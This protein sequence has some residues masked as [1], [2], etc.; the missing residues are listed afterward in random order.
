MEPVELPG[1]DGL[2]IVKF[3]VQTNTGEPF[4]PLAKTASGGEISRIMLAIKSVLADHDQIPVLIFDEIDTGIGGVLASEVGK[5]MCDLSKSHQLLCISH[6][7]QIAS[8]SNNHFKVYKETIGE[9]TV[10]RVI[11]LDTNEKIK[12]IARM[13]GG[14]SEISIKHARELV[15]QGM[16]RLTPSPSP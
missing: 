1:A 14:D 11:N 16:A 2:E 6:L 8:L 15:E 3:L 5:A 12:E 13:L 7:H 10:T 9:R 4:L